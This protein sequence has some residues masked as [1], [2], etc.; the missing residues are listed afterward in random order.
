MTNKVIAQPLMMPSGS[1]DSN[2][3]TIGTG[4]MVGLL[5]PEHEGNVRLLASQAFDGV[6]RPVY[7]CAGSDI[8]ELAMTGSA[9]VSL[10]AAAPFVYLKVRTT[11]PQTAPRE[12]MAVSKRW[13]RL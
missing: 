3:I 2:A 1:V 11:L 12:F 7:D 13:E 9:A 10:D 5:I 6:Y 4:F 8:W